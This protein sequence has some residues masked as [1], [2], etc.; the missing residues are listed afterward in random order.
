MMMRQAPR[1]R[2][3]VIAAGR[4]DWRP[5]IVLAAF[6]FLGA[7]LWSGAARAQEETITSHG[8]TTFGDLSELTYPA[9]YQHLNYVNPDAPKGG[10]ISVWAQGTF[11]S[12]N[13]Y[14]REGLSGA[15]ATIGYESLLEATADTVSD[16]YCLLCE[17]LE[18]P[19]SQDWVIFHMRPEA[20]FSDGTPLTA[21][22]VVFSHNLLMEQGLPSYRE[23][24]A[25]LITN[26]EAL[27]DH[28]VRFTFAP[29]VPRKGLIVQ[30]GGSPVFSQ[31]WYEST[32]ARLD[33]TQVETSPGSGPY[34][35]AAFDFN[36]YITYRRNPDYWGAD[37]PINQGRHNFDEIRVVY[38]A[39][40]NV[41][42][43]AFKAGEYTF[44][45]E[46]SSIVWATGYDFP[47]LNNG[48]VV[49]DE[50]G[51][52]NLPPAVGFV[53]NLRRPEFQDIRVRQAIA[54]MYNFT[55]TND[56]LQYG[57]FQQ[58]NSFWQ[59]S[60]LEA[61]GTP[62]GLE[63]EYLESVAD[64]IDPAILTEPV[65]M[66]HTAGANQL[67]RANLRRALALLTEAGWE[68]GADGR[69]MK[70]GQ[71]LTLE[72]L[73]YSPTF[74]RIVTPFIENLNTLGIAANYNRI[75]PSQYTVRTRAN[76]FDM[77]YD[78]Y[79]T[80]LE[81]GLGLA[82]R[83]GSYAVD[84]VFNPAGYSSPAVD[85]LIEIA[86]DAQNYDEMSAA[87]RGIDRIMRR[88]LFVI[89]SWYNANFWVS[90]YDMFEHPEEMPPYA[91]GQL[92]FWWYNAEKADGLRAAGVIR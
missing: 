60:P 57:L 12:F 13:P 7:A 11:D 44:R 3:R 32:G 22:D 16:A 39:D 14:A 46:N 43:E 18:Y 58:R 91:L 1:S 50:L 24:V 79:T 8:F 78:G 70:D 26:V 72:L 73:G 47:A 61:H 63:L 86:V 5:V 34:V 49:K 74:D 75:D 66:P 88:A 28:T 89:P 54:L 40:A 55:W 30:A 81:E 84:D 2:S 20:R 41:A 17:T 67:D 92:D 15:M 51:N 35:R 64:L 87:V 59:G 21:H 85:R 90:Y 31:A 25:P 82:Q 77:V 52:G 10:T 36:N 38:F 4:R 9:D 27:D 45:Q 53:L 76:D 65:T 23:A 37:L 42:F 19:E 80:G 71:P 48:Y 29:D 68:S 69:L 56:T 6:G 62:E 33:Q 83:F